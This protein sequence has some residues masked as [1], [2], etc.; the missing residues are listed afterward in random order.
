MTDTREDPV[1]AMRWRGTPEEWLRR[2]LAGGLPVRLVFLS[3]RATL[4]GISDQQLDLARIRLGVEVSQIGFGTTKWH[5]Q[6]RY[7]PQ[8]DAPGVDGER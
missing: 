5:W 6:W 1:V 2:Q 8:H 4:A 7:R 3:E